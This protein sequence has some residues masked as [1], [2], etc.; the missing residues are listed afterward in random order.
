[1]LAAG[2]GPVGRYRRWCRQFYPSALK[3]R[4]VVSPERA[5]RESESPAES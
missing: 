5:A 3:S 1:M 2:D 4:A